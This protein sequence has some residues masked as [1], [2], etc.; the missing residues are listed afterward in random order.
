MPNDLGTILWFE[1]RR[2]DNGTAT[3]A[4]LTCREHKCWDDVVHREREHQA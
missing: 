3:D 2:E 1:D 4:R